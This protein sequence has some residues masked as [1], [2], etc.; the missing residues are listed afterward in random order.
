[1]IDDCH[2]QKLLDKHKKSKN[3]SVSFRRFVFSF[4]ASPFTDS[5]PVDNDNDADADNNDQVYDPT[6]ID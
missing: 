3:L 5:G 2:A 4:A 1:M 6:A